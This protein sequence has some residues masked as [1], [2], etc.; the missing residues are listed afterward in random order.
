MHPTDHECLD[1]LDWAEPLT[2]GEI[3]RHLGLTSGAVTGLVDRLERAGWVVRERDPSDRRRVFVRTSH[4]RWPELWPLYRPLAE[5]MGAHRDALDDDELAT[6]V[7]FL[8]LA[9]ASIAAAI[10]H[11]RGLPEPGSEAPG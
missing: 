9:N 4:D 3:A 8:E 11:I 10:E 7:R 2:A 1:L 5:A 6:V